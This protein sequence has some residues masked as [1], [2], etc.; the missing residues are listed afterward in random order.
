MKNTNS[1]GQNL[2]NDDMLP[3]YDFAAGVRGKHYAA[4]REGHTVK[5]HKADGTTDVHYFT[6]EDGAVMLE[7]DVRQYFPDSD[8][9]NKALRALISL[10]PEKHQVTED[11]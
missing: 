6:L 10:V 8:A 7:P 9:V 1:E 11:S 5:I 4:H 3:E 2:E